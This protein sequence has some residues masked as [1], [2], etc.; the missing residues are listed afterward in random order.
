[1]EYNYED[2]DKVVNFSSWNDNK[3]IHELFRIDSYMYANL[4][5]DSTKREKD[6]VRRKSRYIY[7]AIKSINHAIGQELMY[8]LRVE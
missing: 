6:D 7:R 5:T 4:G 8:D 3:K 1:M 2:V